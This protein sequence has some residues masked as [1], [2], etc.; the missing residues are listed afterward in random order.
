MENLANNP[1]Y[2]GQLERMR[3]LYDKQLQHWA[4]EGVKYNG[5]EAY[6]SLF[7]RNINL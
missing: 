2:K 4:E 3:K 5:Y 6:A 7:V 1:T